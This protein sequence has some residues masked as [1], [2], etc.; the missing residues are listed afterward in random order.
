MVLPKSRL[1]SLKGSSEHGQTPSSDDVPPRSK[2][3]VL[4]LPDTFCLCLL[5]YQCVQCTYIPTVSLTFVRCG[6]KMDSIK[7]G[8][9][10]A[11]VTTDWVAADFSTTS[12]AK[13][14][15]KM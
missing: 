2:S 13:I 14:T 3:A 4:L 10:V 15:G 6:R 11:I 9:S 7:E 8:A 1:P 5:L 12:S